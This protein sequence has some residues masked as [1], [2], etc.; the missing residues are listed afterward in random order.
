MG[1]CMRAIVDRLPADH[2][3]V[4]ILHDLKG[5]K[6]REIAEVFGCSL[7]AVEMRTHRA[8]QG[9][10]TLLSEDCEFYHD[11]RDT[12]RCD[13]EQPGEGCRS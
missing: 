11:E 2:R 1:R 3:T 6:N 4:V 12:L 5:F 10:R 8:R 9:L 13:R 7:D